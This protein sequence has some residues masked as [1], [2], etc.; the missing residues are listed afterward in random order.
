MDVQTVQTYHSNFDL[1]WRF[2]GSLT[3]VRAQG[4]EMSGVSLGVQMKAMGEWP[5]ALGKMEEMAQRGLSAEIRHANE[6]IRVCEVDDWPRALSLLQ[7]ALERGAEATE[8][9]SSLVLRKLKQHWPLAISLFH[10]LA[11]Q[12]LEH[13]TVSVNAALSAS[14][15][16][17]RYFEGFLEQMKL[18][19]KTRK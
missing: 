14:S 19:R 5:R 16:E 6:L 10:D 3:K 2:Y 17:R 15:Q 1:F 13:D 18:G 12:R 4:L 7:T 8:F 9:T 11:D